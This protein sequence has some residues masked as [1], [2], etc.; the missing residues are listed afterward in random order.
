VLLAANLGR[1]ADTTSAIAGQLAGA[2]YGRSAIPAEWTAKLAWID[3]IDDI[4]RNL[5]AMKA[6]GTMTDLRCQ[7][8]A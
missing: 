5:F 6:P 3:R 2:L 1:D 7:I 4:G 8:S